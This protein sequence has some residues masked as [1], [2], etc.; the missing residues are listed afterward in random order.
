MKIAIH[1]HIRSLALSESFREFIWELLSS[2][3][4]YTVSHAESTTQTAY[5]E[6]R[7]S[8]GLDVLAML[9]EADPKLYGRLILEQN[10]EPNE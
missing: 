3:G 8:V 10:E 1:E 2:C 9:A 4:L 6:G 7:R 5:N